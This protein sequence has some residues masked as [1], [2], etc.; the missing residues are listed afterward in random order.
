MQKAPLSITDGGAYYIIMSE[1]SF[2]IS[3]QYLS[4]NWTIFG[5]F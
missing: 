3:V 5:L 4:K 2:Y 1:K